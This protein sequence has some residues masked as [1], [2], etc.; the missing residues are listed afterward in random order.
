MTLHK[1]VIDEIYRDSASAVI[2]IASIDIGVTESEHVHH[3]YARV[4][5]D[6]II[7]HAPDATMG[8]NMLAEPVSVD[9]LCETVAGLRE[10][11]R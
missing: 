11:L 2:F 4:K 9:E 7:V 8:F 3:V 6:W 1:Y 10:K 5:P